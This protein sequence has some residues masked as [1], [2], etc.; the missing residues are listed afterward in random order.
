MAERLPILDSHLF[1]VPE[2]GE[3]D[4]EGGSGGASELP[5]PETARKKLHRLREALLPSVREGA[6]VAFSGGVDS[7]FLL[8]AAHDLA[9]STGRGRVAALTTTS[10]STPERDRADAASFTRSLGI[11]HYWRESRELGLPEYARNDRDR[12]YHCKEELFRIAREVADEKGLHWL[13]YGYNASDRS[14]DR[15]GHRAAAEAGVLAPL[16]GVGMEKAE[17]RLLMKEAGLELADKPASP[18][19]SSRIMTGMPV[20]PERLKDV[21]ALEAILR[22]SGISTCRVRVCGAEGNAPFLRVEVAPDEMEKVLACR[23]ELQAAGR[24][25]GYRWVTLDLGGYRTGGGV[26]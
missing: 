20:T 15:P 13:L 4:G 14:D 26:S 25:R 10:P 11:P 3:R 9:S 6:L 21:E 2:P 7:A 1:P 18:C 24:S 17:I 22:D 16:A 23:R 5:D 12:C 8:W 19:L